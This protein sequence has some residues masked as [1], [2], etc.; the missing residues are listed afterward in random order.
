[1][2]KTIKVKHGNI[3]HMYMVEPKTSV[4]I[5]IGD[6]ITIEYPDKDAET[7]YVTPHNEINDCYKCSLRKGSN[8]CSVYRGLKIMSLLCEVRSGSHSWRRSFIFNKLD[9]ILEDL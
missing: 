4:D 2:M 7:F 5:S 1:M 8:I 3:P 6:M 9:D